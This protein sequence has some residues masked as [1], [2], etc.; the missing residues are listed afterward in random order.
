[1][2]MDATQTAFVNT[3]DP[4]SYT[5]RRFHRFMTSEMAARLRAPR[6]GNTHTPEQV[7]ARVNAAH[8]PSAWAPWAVAVLCP[9]PEFVRH[10]ASQGIS[11][12]Y[13]L[14]RQAAMRFLNQVPTSAMAGGALVGT[15]LRKRM[16]AWRV[17]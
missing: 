12:D 2:N 5:A 9:R 10:G 4:A 7:T 15:W 13:Q 17:S 14:T 8:F 3:P 16:A 11:A 6:Q 1:M